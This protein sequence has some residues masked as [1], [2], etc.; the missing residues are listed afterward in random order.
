M[1]TPFVVLTRHFVG[2]ILQPPLVTD[3]GVDY[4]RRTLA[5]VFAI[6]LVIGLF[7]PRAYSKK[8]IDL[9][10]LL[11]R[12][13]YD[14]ALQA[15]TLLMITVPMLVVALLTVILA[16]ML[17]PDETDY[18]VLSPLPVSRMQIFAA[19]LAALGVV[20]AACLL[21]IDLMASFWFP[22]VTHGWRVRHPFGT[23]L[24]AHAGATLAAS[25]WTFTAIMAAQ[26]LTLVLL[27]R[28]VQGR[29]G[30]AL[31]AS[32]VVALLAAIPFVLGIPVLHVT[33]E[34]VT[35]APLRYLPPV[36]FLG[37]QQT[38]LEGD[39][40]G[41]YAHVASLVRPAFAATLLAIAVCYYVLYRSAERLAD[42]LQ[43]SRRSFGAAPRWTEWIVERWTLRPLEPAR[44]GIVR[45]IWHGLTRSRLHQF[46]F[47]LI[48]GVGVTLPTGPPARSAIA[49]PLLLGLA[50]ALALRMS[51]LLPLDR[52]AAWVFRMTEDPGTRRRALDAVFGVVAVAV[53]LP[54]LSLGIVR[55]ATAFGSAAIVSLTLTTLALATLAEFILTDWRR[56]PFTCSYLPG[57]RV[58]AYTLGVLFASYAVFVYLGAQAIRW[59]AGRPAGSVVAG[60]LFLAVFVAVRRSRRRVWGVLPLEFEDEDPMAARP[61]VLTGDDRPS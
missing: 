27:P 23:R 32:V 7:L 49:Q 35:S 52:P 13:V 59:A 50:I 24:A 57:K 54:A 1:G 15:D 40:P 26:G 28:G 21:A 14:R 11:D 37:V 29:A 48:A 3:L 38:M 8:Y 30:L 56:I 4:L 34:S 42:S 61:L 47:L 36:W 20:I 6:V 33:Q 39:L 25:T 45:F 43:T 53:V 31:Q 44:A 60:A 10:T 2:A 51:F 18:R 17:F 19:K 12:T 55:Q 16:P 5:S 58:L 41:G 9:G 22:L 46:V